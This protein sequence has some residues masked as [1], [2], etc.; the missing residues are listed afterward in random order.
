M[1]DEAR[2]ALSARVVRSLGSAAIPVLGLNGIG[3]EPALTPD[4]GMPDRRVQLL[5]PRKRF[6]DAVRLVEPMPWRYSWSRRGLL[7]L[8]PG[9]YYWFDGGLELEL[10][11]G[12]PASPLPSVALRELSRT[13]WQGAT[14]GNQGARIPDPSALLAYLAVRAS[15]PGGGHER[16]WAR[17]RSHLA[18]VPDLANARGVARRTGVLP[19]LDQALFMAKRADPRRPDPRPR[20]QG[21]RE[22]PWRIALGVQRHARPRRFGRLL[23]PIPTLGDFDIRCRVLGV[24]TLAERDVFVPTPDAE[25]IATMASEVIARAAAPDVVVDVGTGNGAIAVAVAATHPAVRVVA[26]ELLARSA[27]CAERNVRRLGLTNARVLRGSLLDPVPGELLGR[28]TLVIANLPFY[29]RRGYA[30]VGSVPRATIQGD[31]DDGLGLVRRLIA[32]AP[33]YLA[34]DGWLLLQMFAWQWKLLG[35][36]LADRGFRPGT[37]APTGPFVIAPAQRVSR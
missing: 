15:S 25:L 33:S 2:S 34:R 24:E 26:T 21:W 11:W 9:A 20:F 22:V 12:V 30:T 31:G 27:R 29:P 19:A 10:Y 1:E 13:L 35:P 6:D 4:A 28:A 23:T 36:E 37:P 3:P 8:A 14:T 32:Q 17:F 16:D 18:H 5:V 7:R